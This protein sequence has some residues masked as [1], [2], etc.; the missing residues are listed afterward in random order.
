MK[1]IYIVLGILLVFFLPIMKENSQIINNT[2]KRDMDSYL[3]QEEKKNKKVFGVLEIAKIHLKNPLYEQ[4]SEENNVDKNIELLEETLSANEEN[5]I[6]ILAGHS[7]NGPHAYFKNLDQITKEDS[8]YLHYQEE[9]IEYQLFKK[10]EVP[11]TGT[12]YLNNYNFSVLALITCSKQ[13]QNIQEVYY[14]KMVKKI[15]KNE[16]ID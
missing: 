15:P 9:I 12:V 2:Q 14:A 11:K 10:E 13:K 1:K 7:G 5:G 16:K 8:I 3:K 4:Y 6:L